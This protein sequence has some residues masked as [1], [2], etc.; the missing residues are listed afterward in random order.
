[1]AQLAALVVYALV[2]I[3]TPGP[4]N[5]SSAAAG[6]KLG[7]KRSLPYRYGMGI[8]LWPSSIV[9]LTRNDFIV[10]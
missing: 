1:M 3:F 4:N 8:A 6:A 9:E 2:S 10:P 7:W 5:V